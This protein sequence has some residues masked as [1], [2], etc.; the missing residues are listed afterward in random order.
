MVKGC[1]DVGAPFVA[2]GDP[3]ET[4]EPRQGAFD[5]PAVA[6]QAPVGLNAAPGDARDDGAFA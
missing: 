3:A 1:E 2:D 4:G 5:L 6:A